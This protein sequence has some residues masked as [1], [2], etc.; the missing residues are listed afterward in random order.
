MGP[1]GLATWQ[2]LVGFV[3]GFGFR[4]ARILPSCFIVI[5]LCPT[6][7]SAQSQFE[8]QPV[9]EVTV[10]FEGTDRNASANELFRITARDALGPTYTAV[11]VREAIEKLY[12]LNQIA[13]VQVEAT[14]L[15]NRGVGVRFI[16]RRKTQAQ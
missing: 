3:C 7:S 4:R 15:A 12:D 14:Q 13:A 1:A 9:A 6:I 16:V 10:T 8:D 5:V 2:R 11:K